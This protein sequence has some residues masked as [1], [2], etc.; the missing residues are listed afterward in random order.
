MRLIVGDTAHIAR[1]FPDDVVKIPSRDIPG[2][3]FDAS[4]EEVH[5]VFGLNMKGLS[6]SAYDEVNH[7]YTLEVMEGFRRRSR[8]IVLYSTCE[9]WSDCWGPI[10]LATP[11][12]F[13]DDPYI[14]SKWR[15]VDRV[16]RMGLRNVVIIFPFNHNSIHRKADFLFG[17][18]FQSIATGTP[19][20]IGDTHYYRDLLHSAYVAEVCQRLTGDTIIGSGRM[21]FVND[22]IRDLYRRFNRRYEDLVRESAG[23]WNYIPK[24]EYYLRGGIRYP[25]ERLLADTVKDLQ[26]LAPPGTSSEYIAPD[27]APTPAEGT[28]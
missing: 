25:Y 22:F 3:L 5:L 19:V 14:L 23:K 26:S 17:K 20:E 8:R 2:H 21:V 28:A 9:L 18:V 1:Y 7:L 11:F 6:P 15:I 4:Y 12:R 13:H 27:G 10:D 16:R 24:N